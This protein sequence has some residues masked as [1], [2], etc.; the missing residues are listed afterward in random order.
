MAIPAHA[1]LRVPGAGAPGE[2]MPGRRRSGARRTARRD[3]SHPWAAC[4]RDGSP[5]RWLARG[6]SCR[7]PSSREP[8]WRAWVWRASAWRGRWCATARWPGPRGGTSDAAAGRTMARASGPPGAP[9]LGTNRAPAQPPWAGEIHRSTN[10]CSNQDGFPCGTHVCSNNLHVSGKLWP[11][12]SIRCYSLVPSKRPNRPSGNGRSA[13]DL[14]R[15]AWWLGGVPRGHPAGTSPA[16][17]T[18]VVA[19]HRR[20][21][22]PTQ[23]RDAAAGHRRETAAGRRPG[24]ADCASRRRR[25]RAAATKALSHP[26]AQAARG[27]RRQRE[28]TA[29]QSPGALLSQDNIEHFLADSPARAEC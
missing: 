7:G 3:T 6:P 27:G 12:A 9:G 26:A 28:A 1:Q 21:A 15:P 20:D 18:V 13:R 14:P 22:A 4:R 23:R 2:R 11:L 19:G 10:M 5:G 16:A 29:G 24:S 17:R 8:A 25:G